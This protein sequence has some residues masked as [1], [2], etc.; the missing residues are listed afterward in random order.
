MLKSG[1]IVG[2]VALVLAICA[3]VVVSPICTPCLA[4][5]LG[6]GAGYLAGQFERPLT[7]DA[8]MK[9]GALAG[10]IGGVGAVLGDAIGTA[11]KVA[12]LGPAGAAQLAQ[13]L[14]LPATGATFASGFWVGLVLSALCFGLVDLVFMAGLGALG[15]MA[16]WRT[17]GK[18][19]QVIAPLP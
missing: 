6:A 15:G 2:G 10:L 1:L 12:M 9:R 5:V 16:W 19:E 3:I 17:R 7:S 4:L 13:S 8:A 11:I 14:G 18:N